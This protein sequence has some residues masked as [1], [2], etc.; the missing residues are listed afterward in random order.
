MGNRKDKGVDSILK[1]KI[2]YLIIGIAIISL[3][4]GL[5]KYSTLQSES[6][7]T[8]TPYIFLEPHVIALDEKNLI[9]RYEQPSSFLLEKSNGQIKN[10]FDQEGFDK[11]A[12]NYYLEIIET[13]SPQSTVNLKATLEHSL[14]PEILSFVND[15][16]VPNLGEYRFE[17][18][19]EYLMELN[20]HNNVVVPSMTFYVILHNSVNDMNCTQLQ[21]F[22]KENLV[23]TDSSTQLA[24]DRLLTDCLNFG[25]KKS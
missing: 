13:N 7:N 3:T 1:K 10:V 18:N 5:I 15:T 25:D 16:R 8:D 24:R 4:V 2:T 21:K 19:K 20:N 17:L 9:I 22:L 12:S 11:S 6:N 23:Q 14:N